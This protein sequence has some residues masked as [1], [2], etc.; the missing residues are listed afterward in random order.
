MVEGVLPEFLCT[1]FH[2][3]KGEYG[4]GIVMGYEAGGSLEGYLAVHKE[5][6][7]VERLRL[8]FRAAEGLAELHALGVVHG[9]IK[10]E[11]VLL[12]DSAGS[13]VRPRILA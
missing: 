9:D 2:L 5:L 6:P 13:Q 8:V 12:S 4:I 1:M 10:P 7:L 11:N 3:E